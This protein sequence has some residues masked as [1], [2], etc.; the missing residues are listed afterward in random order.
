M[1][2]SEKESANGDLQTF[3]CFSRLPLEIRHM[4]WECLI[5]IQRHL[6][7]EGRFGNPTKIVSISISQGS[8][9]SQVCSESRE[10]LSRISSYQ[11]ATDGDGASASR[12][13][14]TVLMT[15]L[16]A[17]VL[18]MF[19]V[20]AT[21]VDCIAI[22]RPVGGQLQD[23]HLA[24]QKRVAAGN[25]PVKAVYTAISTYLQDQWLPRQEDHPITS[26]SD[27]KVIAD[28]DEEL[29]PDFDLGYFYVRGGRSFVA[30]LA[31]LSYLNGF[32]EHDRIAKELR[33][34]WQGLA[35]KDGITAPVLKPA[36]ILTCGTRKH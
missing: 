33:S 6:R 15:T 17:P 32:W 26:A 8:F 29:L 20:L 5:S 3:S 28:D 21:G 12:H 23:L 35:S 31:F 19:S 24:L 10:V 11:A 22:P 30:K 14:D 9:L 36:M 4:I 25:R 7:I 1:D 16:D 18:E 34:T 2:L 13:V 27:F